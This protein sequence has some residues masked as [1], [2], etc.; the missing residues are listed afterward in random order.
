MS[1]F[2]L[3]GGLIDKS[4]RYS[5]NVHGCKV[6]YIVG[7]RGCDGAAKKK[8]TYKLDLDARVMYVP[9]Q[10]SESSVPTGTY[11][12]SVTTSKTVFPTCGTSL[13]KGRGQAD[14]LMSSGLFGEC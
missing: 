3:P 10:F 1:S 9:S 13:L 5:G 14:T 7:D 4:S 6:K 8:I 12:S 2:F 11:S